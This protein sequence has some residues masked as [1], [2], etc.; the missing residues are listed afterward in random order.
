MGTASSVRQ[1]SLSYRRRRYPAGVSTA[2]GDL[3]R[4]F[5]TAPVSEGAPRAG[6][7]ASGGVGG[8]GG[9]DVGGDSRGSSGPSGGTSYGSRGAKL[10]RLTRLLSDRA[11]GTR[12]EVRGG[13]NARV[14]LGSSLVAPLAAEV[15]LLLSPCC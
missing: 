8:G 7:A 2:S 1:F 5:A 11:V 15:Y 9:V 4:T 13:D 10:L 6:A 12:S 3:L 14:S